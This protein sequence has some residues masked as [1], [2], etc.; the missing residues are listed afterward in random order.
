MA[1]FAV[2][3]AMTAG[4]AALSFGARAIAPTIERTLMPVATSVAREVT[5]E[6]G[7]AAAQVVGQSAV[8]Q[9]SSTINSA[10]SGPITQAVGAIVTTGANTA[11]SIASGDI[12]GAARG[13]VQMQ[14]NE[15]R[16]TQAVYSG[17]TR[18][19]GE[20]HAQTVQNSTNRPEREKLTAERTSTSDVTGC[21]CFG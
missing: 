11:M 2:P 14:D 6:A 16:L 5:R 1:F 8:D 20:T 18:T 19:D 13:V 15:A 9:I 21:P 4:R 7:M 3:L 10:T 17:L 12:V